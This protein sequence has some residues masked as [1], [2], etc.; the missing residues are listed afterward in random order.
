MKSNRLLRVLKVVVFG[1]LAVAAVTFVVMSLWNVLMPA[2]FAVKAITF[3]QALGLLALSKILFGG[4]RSFPGG[5]R[6]SRRR[7]FERWEEMTPEERQK[8]K[9]GMRR[10]CGP[11]VSAEPQASAG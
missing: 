2:I 11:A 3:W 9:Q 8:F 6:G 7:M 5:G 10:G 4:F 1:A